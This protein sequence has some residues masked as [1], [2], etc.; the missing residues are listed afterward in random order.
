MMFCFTI[1]STLAA[2]NL[3]PPAFSSSPPLPK[4]LFY[5][6]ASRPESLK[7]VWK[8]KDSIAILLFFLAS[9]MHFLIFLKEGEVL[10]GHGWV[11]CIYDIYVTSSKSRWI[12]LSLLA[13]L[14]SEAAQVQLQQHPQWRLLSLEAMAM[15]VRME[16]QK[17][18]SSEG[19]RKEIPKR[20]APS[21]RASTSARPPPPTS[22]LAASTRSLNIS[23]APLESSSSNP[24]APLRS[25]HQS[26]KG[27]RYM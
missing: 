9:S 11:I 4:L 23:F 16:R 20:Q 21:Q 27:N 18:K 14:V 15:A 12:G 22:A 24:S 1:I 8:V 7:A 17:K 6:T 2:G 13:C 25:A 26:P 10:V 3:F 19:D 5:A